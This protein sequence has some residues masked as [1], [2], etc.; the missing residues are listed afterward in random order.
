M[1]AP[2]ADLDELG[3]AALR[4]V[5]HV[6]RRAVFGADVQPFSVGL[7]TAC[8]GF[9]PLTAMLNV[10]RGFARG[11]GPRCCSLPRRRRSRCVAEIP[12]FGDFPTG[13]C[14]RLRAWRG[15]RSGARRRL[16]AHVERR[17][18]GLAAMPRGLPPLDRRDDL[19]ACGVD[20]RYRADLSLGTYAKGA[21]HAEEKI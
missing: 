17:P 20:H 19:V 8:S 12:A 16:V 13:I 10:S 6:H 7:N 18:S 14:P 15:P 4:H 5:D 21:A 3:R 9:F 2:L 11:S 1:R